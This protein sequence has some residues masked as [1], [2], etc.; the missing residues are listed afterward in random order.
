VRCSLCVHDHRHER[1]VIV[2]MPVS[3]T[4]PSQISRVHAVL[5]AAIQR[6]RIAFTVHG[7]ERHLMQPENLWWALLVAVGVFLSTATNTAAEEMREA[8]QDPFS[9]TSS[10]SFLS[11][12]TGLKTPPPGG[13]LARLRLCKFQDSE[14]AE[15]NDAFVRL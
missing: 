3:S 11:S 10:H 8:L 2:P 15:R 9:K 5:L 12:C 1:D 4:F 6:V 13:E 7:N 14:P